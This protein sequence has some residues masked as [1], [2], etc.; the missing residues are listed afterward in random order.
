MPLTLDSVRYP[1]FV[2][3]REKYPFSYNKNDRIMKFE[4]TRRYRGGFKQ[5]GYDP[6]RNSVKPPYVNIYE[7]LPRPR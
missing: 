3:Y 2:K 5:E 4:E 7:V 6:K 1:R